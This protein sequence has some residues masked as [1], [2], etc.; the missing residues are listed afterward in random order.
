MEGH[1][2]MSFKERKRL[3]I[4]ERVKA[5]E[6]NLKQAAGLLNISYRQARRIYQRYHKNGDSGL[7]HQNRGK[8]S[9][10]RFS[11]EFQVQVISLYQSNYHDFGPTLAAEKLAKDGFL[12]DHETLRRWLKNA[13][14]YQKRRKRPKHRV[15]R[16]RKSHFGE[17]IQLDGSHHRWFEERG[18]KC[19]LMNMVDDATGT[20]LALLAEEE[21]TAAAM[22]LLW[23]WVEK[24]GIPKALYTDRK[25]VYVTE[26]EPSLA[27]QLK[28]EEPLTQFGQA[29]QKLGIEIILAYSPQAKGRV[30]RK[31]GVHQDRLV[32]ELRLQKINNLEAANSF[33]TREYLAEHN[34]K[35]AVQAAQEA[36]Y[37]QAVDEALD[38]R[39]VFC[40]E[41]ERQISNDWTVRYKNKYLQIL[42]QKNLPPV[43]RKVRVQ[44]HLDGSL[45]IVYRG[46]A[47]EFQELAKRP[48]K[49]A[50]LPIPKIRIKYIPPINH[51]WRRSYKRGQKI[52]GIACGDVDN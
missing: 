50:S 7:L 10:R 42:R 16:E 52:Q 40:L 25:N 2:V 28:N 49:K 14:L 22:T 48:D 1:L 3:K 21:T 41:E 31:N 8:P 30:E 6:L 46:R 29:C 5:G 27:E 13:G 19:C 51:P 34:S 23:Q 36:D 44:E 24:Y 9:N 12:L 26:R 20:T 4:M 33:L 15:W 18:G 11:P 38:L 45:H 39:M 17:L 43:K 47:V 37:H 32:K 35:F